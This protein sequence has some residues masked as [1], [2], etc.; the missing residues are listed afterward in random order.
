MSKAT[1]AQVKERLRALA[2][3]EQ[4]ALLEGFFKTGPGEYGE[5]DR[6]LGIMVPVQRKVSREFR[7]IPLSEIRKLLASG[8]HEHRLVALLIMVSMFEAGDETV[9]TAVFNDYL[10]STARINNWDLVDL[11]APRIVG[12]FLQDRDRKVLVKLAGSAS[13]WERR[14][15]I[16]ATMWFIRN[17]D[18]ADTFRIVS[19]VI[20]DRED[21]IHKAAGWMLREVGKRDRQAEEAFL[22]PRYSKMPR[23]MLRYA[24]E[25]FPEQLRKAYLRG[26]V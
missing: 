22:K 23:T 21:L 4:A 19:M 6:F 5:G 12:A 2:N 13:L 24:I 7:D 3:P 1:A 9:R 17:N 11:S 16:L 18:F 10:A 20:E 25:R 8:I 26:A 14:I 15:A